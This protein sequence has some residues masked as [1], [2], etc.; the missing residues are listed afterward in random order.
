MIKEEAKEI[1]GY[2]KDGSIKKR[3][4]FFWVGAII[5]LTLLVNLPSQTSNHKKTQLKGDILL[6][7]TQQGRAATVDTLLK[8]MR[9][10]KQQQTIILNKMD[11]TSVKKRK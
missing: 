7:D 3:W 5:L 10:I 1:R 2:L 6:R 4:L 9:D 11:S 8:E